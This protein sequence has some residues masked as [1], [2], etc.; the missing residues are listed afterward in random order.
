MTLKWTPTLSKQ[1]HREFP[2]FQNYTSTQTVMSTDAYRDVKNRNSQTWLH[3]KPPPDAV[4]GCRKRT[5]GSTK[6]TGFHKR[7]EEVWEEEVDY[8]RGPAASVSTLPPWTDK[9]V[10]VQPGPTSCQGFHLWC[11]DTKVAGVLQTLSSCPM[12]VL[13]CS[14]KGKLSNEMQEKVWSKT[15]VDFCSLSWYEQK[16]YRPRIQLAQK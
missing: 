9:M 12:V 5:G 14:M 2:L 4:R 7:T 16:K 10:S 15:G 3:I 11:C 8:R 1:Q 6:I 13:Q